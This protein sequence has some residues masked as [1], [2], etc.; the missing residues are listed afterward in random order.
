M[1]LLFRVNIFEKY[2]EIF[3]DPFFWIIVLV[4]AAIAFLIYRFYI[5]NDTS[6][7]LEDEYLSA[8]LKHYGFTFLHSA[9]QTSEGPF[10]TNGSNLTAL[11]NRAFS[12]RKV[13]AMNNVTSEPVEF[14]AKLEYASSKLKSVTWIPNPGQFRQVV[15]N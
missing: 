2:R 11:P 3:S 15:N 4:F 13:Q 1:I 6:Y 8:H 10:A 9:T 12:Y 14:W 7:S 5:V